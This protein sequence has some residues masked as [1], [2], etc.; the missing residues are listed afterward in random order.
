MKF[1]WLKTFHVSINVGIQIL[2]LFLY[3]TNN[4]CKLIKTMPYSDDPN[5]NPEYYALLL[6]YLPFIRAS[7]AGPIV[8]SSEFNKV[9]NIM[10][11]ILTAHST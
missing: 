2:L 8:L 11:F 6:I 4:S 3:T 10:N 5:A 9:K 1:L 7:K